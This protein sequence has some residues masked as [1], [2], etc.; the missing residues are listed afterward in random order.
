[1]PETQLSDNLYCNV[2]SRRNTYDALDNLIYRSYPTA[3]TN[4]A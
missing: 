3:K 4:M 1:M 2:F